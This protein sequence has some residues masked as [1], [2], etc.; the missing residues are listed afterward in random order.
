MF[1]VASVGVLRLYFITV[2][3]AQRLGSLS[4][5]VS[6]SDTWSS[7]DTRLDILC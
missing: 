3:D 6:L 5:S 7:L 4:K 2:G 1:D